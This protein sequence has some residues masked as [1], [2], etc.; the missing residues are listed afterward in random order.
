VRQAYPIERARIEPLVAPLLSAKT[1]NALERAGD[2]QEWAALVLS[3]P[4]FM[5]R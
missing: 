5:Y 3:A 2:P 4:E 1:R